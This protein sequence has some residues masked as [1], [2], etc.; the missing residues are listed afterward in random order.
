MEENVIV[1][2]TDLSEKSVA[3]LRIGLQHARATD[4]LVRIIYVSP[5]FEIPA[6]LQRQLSDPQG[7]REMQDTYE[8]DEKVRLQNFLDEHQIA[9]NIEPVVEF[10]NSTPSSIILQQ[11]EQQ[12]ARLIVMS[13]QGKGALGRFFLG[14][15][16]Q[17]VVA[18]S[19]CPVLIIPHDY[20]GEQNTGKAE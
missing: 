5:I 4:A 8:A 3:A 7:L 13:S 2:T 1:I 19:P 17:K 15:T 20:E 14:S 11:A 12:H 9:G 18:Q 10:S 16:T 6:A